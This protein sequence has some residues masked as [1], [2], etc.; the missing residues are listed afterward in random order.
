MKVDRAEA[1]MNKTIADAQQKVEET[2]VA[3]RV[4]EKEVRENSDKDAER[5]V[6]EAQADAAAKMA[7]AGADVI[8]ARSAYDG[9]IRK[10]EE[11]LERVARAFDRAYGTAEG[12]IYRAQAKVDHLQ[13][14]IDDTNHNIDQASKAPASQVRTSLSSLFPALGVLEAAKVDEDKELLSQ[15]KQLS[16]VS[17]QLEAARDA[18]EGLVNSAE[19]LA[20]LTAK[21]ALDT[22][23]HTGAGVLD[24]VNAALEVAKDAAGGILNITEDLFKAL[25]SV[26]NITKIEITTDLSLFAGSFS[27]DAIV[28][29]VIVGEQFTLELI[30]DLKNVSSL[31]KA[32]LLE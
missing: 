9:D 16:K 10:K 29:R 28:K 4:H 32:I 11:E 6:R 26:L 13:R 20:Y 23:K 25:E 27:F 1:E 7:K 19:R 12:D 18:I 14:Q 8:K 21:D 31:I 5:K 2:H 17:K 15:Q 3:W 22:A 30:L 24:A